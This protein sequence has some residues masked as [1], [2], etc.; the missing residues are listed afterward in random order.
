M[1]DQDKRKAIFLLHR[2]GMK[3]RDISF[4]L[5][6]S[7]NT[8]RSIIKQGGRAPCS[9]RGD[10]I[11]IDQELLVRLYD[12]CAGRIQ[13][14]HEKLAEEEGVKIGYST[15]SRLIRELGLGGAAKGRC[16]RVPDEP[17]A[18]MQHDTSSYI[19][20]IG[21]KSIKVIGSILYFR[22]SKVR[23][24]KFYRSFDR[25]K[26]KCFFHEALTFFGYSAR[27]CII[28]NTNLARLRGSGKNAIIVPEMEQFAR[29]FGFTYVCHE[30]N[31]PNRKAG[32]ERS[33]YTVE[34]NFFPGRSFESMEDLNQKALEWATLRMANRPVSRSGLIPA[35]A[36]EHEKSYLVKLPPFVSPP[37]L[38]HK[39][40]ID[41]YGYVAFDGNFY[42]VPGTSRGEALLL[43]YSSDL[44][45]YLAQKLLAE[46]RLP[47]WGVK[48]QLFT[49]GGVPKPE[50][51]PKNRKEPTAQEEKNLRALDK[52]VDAYLEFVLKSKKGKEKH[53]VIRELFGLYQKITMPLF[54]KTIKRALC[55]RITD[56][57]CVERIALLYL[58]GGE[59]EIRHVPIDQEFQKRPAYLEGRLSDEANLAVYEKLLEDVLVEPK[60][61]ED[62][63]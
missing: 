21:G 29:Q 43:Q 28:D 30:L 10:K 39:R 53:K 56:S 59:G 19:L 49:P 61:E 20:P 46:Y 15:L 14:I 7:R 2:E 13:R 60:V 36:F 47:P 40:D 58:T 3:I 9:V 6:I 24:L 1:I 38:A 25:F 63:S 16:C 62:E 17:G 44:K 35:K 23:Y 22:Y 51:K 57:R 12:E 37:Y 4:R 26:M 54:I 50:Y 11:M 31:H 8:V 48:N 5:K 41:Q 18:E 55:Y 52:D 45:V 27:V 34:T 33:F 42:W 32:N